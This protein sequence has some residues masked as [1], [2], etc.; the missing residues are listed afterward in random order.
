MP[1]ANPVLGTMLAA[2]AIVYSPVRLAI[3]QPALNVAMIMVL[4]RLRDQF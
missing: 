4:S 1:E 3:L 2:L